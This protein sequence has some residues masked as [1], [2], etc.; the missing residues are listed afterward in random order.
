MIEEQLINEVGNV[1]GYL[2][3]ISLNT[4]PKYKNTKDK[5]L[6]A[7]WNCECKC[8]NNFV[9]TGHA[10]RT[11]HATSCGCRSQSLGEEKIEKLLLENNLNYAK[12]Y[13]I[14]LDDNSKGYYDFAIFDNNQTLLYLIEF[15][16]Q[17]HYREG[18]KEDGHGWGNS[19][20]LY[21]K[22]H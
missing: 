8:G 21:Q 19:L 14:K 20:E 7:F 22:T 18:K 4:D 17:Q 1:Y 16:G 9:T 5:K 10:L 12:E 2:T 15:D 11:G 6:R 3:V 13:F